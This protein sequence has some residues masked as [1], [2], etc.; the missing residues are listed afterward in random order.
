MNLKPCPF[1]GSEPELVDNRLEW[2]VRCTGCDV[3]VIGKRHAELKSDEESE[4]VD[5]AEFEQSAIDKWNRRV[6]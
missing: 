3:T 6:N 2:Y 1:C 5:W 4:E